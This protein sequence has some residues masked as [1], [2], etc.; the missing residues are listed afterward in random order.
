MKHIFISFALVALLTSCVQQDENVQT[1]SYPLSFDFDN[2]VTNTSSYVFRDDA[3]SG[4]VISRA[5]SGVNFGF[6]YIYAVPDSLIGRN[7]TLDIDAWVR[8]GD[9]N[10]NCELIVSAYTGD[11]LL[12]W[13]GCGVKSFL[14]APNQWTNIRSS[15]GISPALTGNAGVK[16]KVLAHNVDAKSFF[17]VDDL[18]INLR[19]EL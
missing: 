9:L 4:R 16:I 11:S 19:E 12:L 15:V 2:G 14:K 1:F 18:N 13:Q 17:D 5:D 6:S 10:N 7:L 3:H 8:T